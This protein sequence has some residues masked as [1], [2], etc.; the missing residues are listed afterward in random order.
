MTTLAQQSGNVL[1][2]TVHWMW[3][4]L[5]IG[6]TYGWP[7]LLIGAAVLTWRAFRGR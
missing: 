5:E 2:F 4:A 7:L 3:S 6:A 1:D